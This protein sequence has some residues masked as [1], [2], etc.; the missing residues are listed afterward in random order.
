SFIR[1]GSINVS[2]DNETRED[3]ILEKILKRSSV[4]E[5]YQKILDQNAVKS[6]VIYKDINSEGENEINPSNNNGKFVIGERSYEFKIKFQAANNGVVRIYN[7]Y[8]IQLARLK[9][10]AFLFD[11]YQD[12]VFEALDFSSRTRN[13]RKSDLAIMVNKM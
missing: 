12:I 7:D 13:Y 8:G 4:N 2:L 11:S 5:K 1:K 6:E 10:K 9:E 3:M